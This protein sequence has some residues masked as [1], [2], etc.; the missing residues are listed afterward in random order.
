MKTLIAA[1]VAGLLGAGAAV[2]VIAGGLVPLPETTARRAPAAPQHEAEGAEAGAAHN[3][4]G[5]EVARL[6]NEIK[7]MQLALDRATAAGAAGKDAEKEIAALK[8][9]IAALKRASV[10][11]PRSGEG[12]TAGEAP[13]PVDPAFEEA[14]RTVNAKLDAEKQEQRRLDRQAARIA[15]LEAGKQ[16]IAETIPKFVQSQAQR[17]NLDETQVAAVS[18]ALVAHLTARADIT[19][20]R[21]GQRIDDVEV[22]DAAFDKR[23][24]DLDATT[25]AALTSTLPKDAAENILRSANRMGGGLRNTGPQPAQRNPGQGGQGRGNRGGGNGN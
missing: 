5:A 1:I 2:G 6:R 4:S 15:D 12:T 16:R 3:D 21:A 13:K 22:D 19:S 9:D 14:V 24:E 25:L 18:N 11:A 23:L 10:A 17:L 20:E 8:A 7:D